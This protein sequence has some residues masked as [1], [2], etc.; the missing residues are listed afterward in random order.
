VSY[1]YVHA[2]PVAQAPTNE[3]AILYD[4]ENR[5][6]VQEGVPAMTLSDFFAKTR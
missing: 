5:L 6:R 4:H 1:P 3:H 2:E